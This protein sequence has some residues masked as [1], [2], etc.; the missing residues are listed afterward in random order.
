[1]Y[2]ALVSASKDPNITPA[3]LQQIAAALEVQIYRDFG[4]FWQFAGMPVK[5]FG[6]LSSIPADAAPLVIFDDPDQSGALGWHHVDPNGRAYGRAFWKV[7]Q[8]YGG[9]LIKT[10]NSL[11]VTLS[12]EALEMIGDPYVDWWARM[13]N[14]QL[15]C[16]EVCDRVQADAYDIDGVWVSDFLGPRAFR[17]GLGPYDFMRVLKSPWEIRRGGYAIRM[18]TSGQ[19]TNVW[20]QDFPDWQKE[21][22]ALPS[23]RTARR[24]LDPTEPAPEPTIDAEESDDEDPTEPSPPPT[25]DEV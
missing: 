25:S 13:P 12:H 15:E 24:H 9:S 17:N 4:P 5:V 8:S 3:L 19:V 22:K 20:G 18:T 6:S 2:L 11:S 7:I 16:L 14:G 10:P 21:L 23:S 1:M